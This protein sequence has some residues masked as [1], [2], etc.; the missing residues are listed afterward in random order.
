MARLTGSIL[1]NLSG[2][3]GNLSARTRNG[4]TYFAARP[5]PRT[6]PP[7][8]AALAIRQKFALTIAF[9][10][11]ALDLPALK[12]IWKK[13]KDPGI[14]AANTM[15]SDNFALVTTDRPTNQNIIT[16]G[17]FNFDLTDPVV[18]ADTI[19]A[20]LDALNTKAVFT[21]ED[22]DLDVNIVV[23]YYNPVD[24][25]DPPYSLINLNYSEPNY[26][27]SAP[28]PFTINYNVN[29]Q[30]LA[31]KYQNNILYIALVTKNGD[32]QIS[33]Y[34]STLAIEG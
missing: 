28:L 22:Q 23:C 20:S 25:L 10:K 14:S 1:G 19:S 11:S 5:G 18:G 15:F 17:G 9:V 21:G 13:A 8:A 34:S 7:T 4:K 12:E 29:Q 31:A 33:Q 2:K 16:P 3:L 27:N 26:V 6:T 32:G 24:P 30:N